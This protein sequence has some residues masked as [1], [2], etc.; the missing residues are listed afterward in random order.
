MSSSASSLESP[1]GREALGQDLAVA[2]VRAVDVVV[3]RQR[4]G[5]ADG[6][7]FLADGEMRGSEMIV[8]DALVDRP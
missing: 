2:A 8:G 6:G 7:R 5:H 3:R 4:E 1:D